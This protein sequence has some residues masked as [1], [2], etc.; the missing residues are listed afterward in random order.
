MRCNDPPWACC[1][2][3]KLGIARDSAER[4]RGCSETEFRG[5]FEEEN[6]GSPAKR[7]KTHIHQ[8]FPTNCNTFFLSKNRGDQGQFE[9]FW[10]INL[11]WL[12]TASI[13]K[14]V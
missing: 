6:I 11:F 8:S 12:I 4:R 9:T 1:P 7:A 2:A 5:R 10:K 13:G 3:E 14:G